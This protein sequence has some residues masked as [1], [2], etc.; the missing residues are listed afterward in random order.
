MN[1]EKLNESIKAQ[2]NMIVSADTYSE[3]FTQTDAGLNIE[4]NNIEA[5]CITSRNNKFNVDSDG[6]LTVN[7]IN[8]N[9]PNNNSLSFETIFNKIYPV[10]AIYIST[11]AI[12]PGV[13]FTGTWEKIE[14]KFLL[15]Y[16]ADYPLMSTGG[17]SEHKHTS[18]AHNHNS[19]NLL[20]DFNFE[21]GYAKYYFVSDD[22]SSYNYIEDI[23][24][25]ETNTGGHLYGGVNIHG[26]TGTTQPGDTGTT[27]HLP[28]YLA[29]NIWK[30]VS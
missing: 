17:T 29:V 1:N 3:Y 2:S 4:A 11:N 28:P 23:S 20:A 7:S 26:L 21:G 18:A 13:I 10:G 6:N 16:S 30:R 25:T 5:N 22:F 19:G 12:N 8:F 27:K 14:N 15:G 24:Y 9:N